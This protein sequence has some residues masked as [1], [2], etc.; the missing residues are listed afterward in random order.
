MIQLYVGHGCMGRHN[1]TGYA[2]L[3]IMLMCSPT[4]QSCVPI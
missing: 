4:E 1:F 3:Y 2:G